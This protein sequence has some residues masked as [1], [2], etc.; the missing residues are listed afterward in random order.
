MASSSAASADDLLLG[1]LPTEV[2]AKAKNP[3]FNSTG[4]EIVRRLCDDP[5]A[6]PEVPRLREHKATDLSA[7]LTY[8]YKPTQSSPKAPRA[9]GV[10]VH[11]QGG[12]SVE[13]DVRVADGA[14]YPVG[15]LVVLISTATVG[16]HLL[17]K[18]FKRMR[19][20]VAAA[21]LAPKHL[22][23]AGELHFVHVAVKLGA[24]SVLP[25]APGTIVPVASSPDD[26]EEEFRDE[27]D[28]DELDEALRETEEAR[29]IDNSVDEH[30]GRIQDLESRVSALEV[31]GSETPPSADGPSPLEEAILRVLH[32]GGKLEKLQIRSRLMAVGFEHRDENGD[33]TELR[34]QDINRALTKMKRDGKVVD[35]D[36]SGARPIWS[37]VR[38]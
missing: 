33:V 9:E 11:C 31:Q 14:E 21:E 38:S 13:P 37:L 28:L 20:K 26:G 8:V 27:I 12:G 34:A 5:N 17:G 4:C 24:G 10:E 18:R 2:K 23:A 7:P 16:D 35:G 22:E 3:E 32:A 25:V 15:S 30:E 6:F 36:K 19:V 1:R 29:E